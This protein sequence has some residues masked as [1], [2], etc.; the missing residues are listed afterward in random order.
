VV[1]VDIRNAFNSADWRRTLE[2]LRSF[3]IPEYL[4][5]V[6]HSYLSKRELVLETFVG[7]STYEMT[8]GD[9]QGLVL[10]PLGTRCMTEF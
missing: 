8:A 2:A 7:P 4:L 10:G 5:S 3:N 6:V 9:T 1:T